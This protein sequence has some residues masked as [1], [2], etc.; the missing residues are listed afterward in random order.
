[1]RVGA[2]T[3]TARLTKALP[4][5]TVYFPLTLS[6]RGLRVTVRAPSRRRLCLTSSKGGEVC[7]R[8]E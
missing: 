7:Y 6:V 1:M 3:R 4:L 2:N 8:A 5:S